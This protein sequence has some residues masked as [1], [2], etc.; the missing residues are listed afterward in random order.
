MCVCMSKR[1]R[2][3][4]AKQEISGVIYKDNCDRRLQIT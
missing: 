3:K 1:E 2:Q 4:D